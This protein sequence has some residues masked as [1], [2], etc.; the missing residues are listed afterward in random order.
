MHNL[1][2]GGWLVLFF[3]LGLAFIVSILVR[4]YMQ[5]E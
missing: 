3:C 4:L 1:I 2:E 5:S